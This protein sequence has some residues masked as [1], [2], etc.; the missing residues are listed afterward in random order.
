MA[1]SPVGGRTVS[2]ARSAAHEDR[3]SGGAGSDTITGMNESSDRERLTGALPLPPIAKR[4]HPR[5]PTWGMRLLGI[6]GGEI[7]LASA[8]PRRAAMLEELGVRF[9]RHPVQVPEEVRPGEDAAQA[10]VRLAQAKARAAGA[11][12]ADRDILVVGADTLVV[13]DGAPLGKPAG[14]EDARRM[15]RELSGRT[16][17]VVTGVA[18]LRT[19][20]GAL[21]AGSE[22]TRVRFRELAEADV[23]ALVASGEAADK[24]GAYGIQG[25]ASLVVD[26]IEGDYFN[27]VGLPLGLLRRLLRD[28][29]GPE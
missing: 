13:L 10:A 22:H 7:V 19:R 14:D 25:L 6:E 23:E 18:V 8:S 4:D 21:F 5:D 17:E 15:L 28:A 12:F 20:D 16:H 9:R 3:A 24:A 11:G 29:V 1:W 2:P 26:G 27:V